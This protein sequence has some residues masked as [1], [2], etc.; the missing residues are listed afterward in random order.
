MS[1]IMTKELLQE[2][3]EFY[4]FYKI[5]YQV[6]DDNKTILGF[7]GS[8][9]EGS[10][11]SIKNILLIIESRLKKLFGVQ[12]DSTQMGHTTT[13]SWFISAKFMQDSSILDCKQRLNTSFEKIAK[14]TETCLHLNKKINYAG[15]A[16]FWY[17]PECKT[18]LGD[19]K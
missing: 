11:S 2:C 8:L 17:C 10:L 6:S 12:F 14:D 1:N 16:A 5:K 13:A 19:V 3:L 9:P 18:D 4:G 7:T 15:G